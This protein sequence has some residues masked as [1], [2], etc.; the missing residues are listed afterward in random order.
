[1]ATTAIEVGTR[2]PKTTWGDQAVKH[3]KFLAA[4][5]AVIF[6]AVSQLAQEHGV[7][8]RSVQVIERRKAR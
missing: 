6:E 5:P 2:S 8:L 4:L 7:T 3:D 1:M